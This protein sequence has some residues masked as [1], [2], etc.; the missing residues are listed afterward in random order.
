VE[1]MLAIVGDLSR[2][3]QFLQCADAQDG[4]VFA[5]LAARLRGYAATARHPARGWPSRSSRFGGSSRERRM[6]DQ[7]R[8]NWNR[9][10]RWLSLFVELQHAV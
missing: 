8:A 7:N 1:R 4:E 2:V 3:W 5:V 6:V 10:V 9:V